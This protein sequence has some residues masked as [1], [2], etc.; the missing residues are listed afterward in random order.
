MSVNQTFQNAAEQP[1]PYPIT[2]AGSAE[3]LF[4]PMCL[5]SHWDATKILT[6][7]LPDQ[8]VDLPLDF[9][10][11]VKICKNYVTSAP[12]E[13]APLPPKNM[14]F[15]MGGEFYPPG[16]YSA[17]INKESVLHYL[18]RTLDRW[19]QKDEYVSPLTSDMYIANSTV[20]RTKAPT[21][22]LVQELAMPKAVTRESAYHCRTEND[23]K[24]WNRSPRLFSNP[25]KQDRYGAQT[26]S[27]LPGGVL[28]YPHGGVETVPLTNQAIA[29][30]RIVG[31]MRKFGADGKGVYVDGSRPTSDAPGS[32]GPIDIPGGYNRYS[33]PG[34]I[35]PVK[36]RPLKQV[37]GGVTTAGMYAPA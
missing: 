7:I 18:D 10:P 31:S 17:N 22:A 36:E 25:T 14:V 16:R 13:V 15:P 24:L 8:H 6:H 4:P 9:R 11:Y 34:S 5:R 35:R 32:L 19:C 29:G 33:G 26:Y 23:I 37:V 27:S 28:V 2:S 3:E 30:A 21:S 20:V 1:S 12:A